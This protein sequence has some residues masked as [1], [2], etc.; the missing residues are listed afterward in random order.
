M[1]N[2]RLSSLWIFVVAVVVL[3]RPLTKYARFPQQARFISHVRVRTNGR[4]VV[5]YSLDG[6]LSYICR[7]YHYH[8]LMVFTTFITG[9]DQNTIERRQPNDVCVDVRSTRSPIHHTSQMSSFLSQTLHFYLLT[10]TKFCCCCCC[11]CCC[12]SFGPSRNVCHSMVRTIMRFHYY[13]HI[14]V[15]LFFK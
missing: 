12:C 3:I 4:C 9:S 14:K 2:L 13:F 11:C 10:D 8:H 1:S 7:W 15:T 5:I 6:A